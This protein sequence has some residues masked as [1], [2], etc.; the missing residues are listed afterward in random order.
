[1][2]S[3]T[4]SADATYIG[5]EADEVVELVHRNRVTNIFFTF[6]QLWSVLAD[7]E[8]NEKQWFSE[9]NRDL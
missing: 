3:R 1:M 5:L 2:V 6:L 9:I 8:K 7:V 4:K